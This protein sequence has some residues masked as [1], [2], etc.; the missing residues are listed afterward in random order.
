VFAQTSRWPQAEEQFRAETKLRPGDAEAAYRLGD[1]LLQQGK[2]R[3]ARIELERSDKLQPQMPE[4]LYALGKAS[5]L[6]GAPAAAEQAWKNLL[7]IEKEG[8]L[9]AQAHFGLAGLYRK[10][11]NNAKAAEHMLEFQK[12]QGSGNRQEQ[13]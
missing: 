10:Q 5:S 6:D 3:A 4:T 13:K 7:N 8:T 1:A 11:G 2:S 9:A 12:L